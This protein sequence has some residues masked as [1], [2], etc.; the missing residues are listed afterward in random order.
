M[1]P[2]AASGVGKV[3]FFHE[4][5][6]SL[7]SKNWSRRIIQTNAHGVRLS[8]TPHMA[9]TGLAEGETAFYP[10]YAFCKNLLFKRQE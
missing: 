2:A 9:N 6:M 1:A 10:L 8:L 4:K 3:F 7:F 5:K